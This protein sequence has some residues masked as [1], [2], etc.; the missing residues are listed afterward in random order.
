VDEVT[1]TEFVK[2]INNLAAFAKNLA[3]MIKEQT[4][5]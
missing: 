5:E 4:N 1:Q 2:A 3:Q